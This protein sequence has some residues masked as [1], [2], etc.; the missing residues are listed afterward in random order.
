MTGAATDG[1]IEPNGKTILSHLLLQ[2]IRSE[3]TGIVE[4]PWRGKK[5]GAQ[6]FPPTDSAESAVKVPIAPQAK[7]L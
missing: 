6:K 1:A 7:P 5:R 3:V 2:E 4:K